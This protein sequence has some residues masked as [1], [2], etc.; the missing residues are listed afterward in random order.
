MG[1]LM[2]LEKYI[3]CYKYNVSHRDSFIF[4]CYLILIAQLVPSPPYNVTI[5]FYKSM[6]ITARSENLISSILQLQTYLTFTK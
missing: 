2:F 6:E 4:C 3:P 5:G 1:L